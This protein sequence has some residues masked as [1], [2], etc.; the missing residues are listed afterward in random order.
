MLK[1]ED[2]GCALAGTAG[3]CIIDIR[4]RE[5]YISQRQNHDSVN[6]NLKSKFPNFSLQTHGYYVL[7]F[8]DLYDRA[9]CQIQT[10]MKPLK[11]AS[12]LSS[13][14]MVT[15]ANRPSGRLWLTP[16]KHRS[17]QRRGRHPA[18]AY[19][20][21]A[22]KSIYCKASQ[23]HN[24]RVSGRYKSFVYTLFDIIVRFVNLTCRASNWRAHQR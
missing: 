16:F 3:L 8:Y 18:A 15:N 19:D 23:R 17:C 13:T 24:I 12:S 1:G 20:T 10:V 5:S 11:V 7:M 9:R 4:G 2:M 6:I 22:S 21:K 14:K